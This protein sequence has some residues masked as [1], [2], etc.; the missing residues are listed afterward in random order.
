MISKPI[1]TRLDDNF[2]FCEMFIEHALELGYLGEGSTKGMALDSLQKI[3]DSR[4][5][6]EKVNKLFPE[7]K[8]AK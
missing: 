6:I 5:L 2:E 4:K 7:I 1:L 8:E 3:K